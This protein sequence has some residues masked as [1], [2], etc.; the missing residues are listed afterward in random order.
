[1]ASSPMTRPHDMASKGQRHGRS[2]CRASD[3][4]ATWP[5]GVC[6]DTKFSIVK[7]DSD[8]GSDTAPS[9]LRYGAG[10]LRHGAQRA[11]QGV[12][13]SYNFCIMTGG[14]RHG[15]R[16]NARHGLRHCLCALR[17]GRRGGHDMMPCTPRHGAQRIGVC[18]V[19]SIHFLLSALFTVTVHE[20]LFMNTV[21]RVFKI[22]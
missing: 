19:H 3:T 14:L 18:T 13:S 17:H 10:A 12:E 4:R 20:I 15:A 16:H 6:H 11:R 21:N 8:T 1:M 5:L 22:K 9:T 2:A 7:K